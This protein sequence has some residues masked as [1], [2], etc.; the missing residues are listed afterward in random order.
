MLGF[1]GS[2]KE[3]CE[4]SIQNFEYMSF[5]CNMKSHSWIRFDFGKEPNF[6]VRFNF[7][8]KLNSRIRYDFCIKSVF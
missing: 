3:E 7:G 2:H 1:R 4:E 5:Y 6:S 8:F